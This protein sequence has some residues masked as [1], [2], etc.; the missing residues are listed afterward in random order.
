MTRRP[1]LP[2]TVYILSYIGVAPFRHSRIIGYLLLPETYRSL[3]RL[4]SASDTKAFTIHLCS[5]TI[6]FNPIS[7]SRDIANIIFYAYIVLLLI[8]TSCDFYVLFVIV[9]VSR[10]HP[11]SDRNRKRLVFLIYNFVFTCR[12]KGLTVNRVIIRI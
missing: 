3:S 11:T 4:S 6:F 9:C 12:N 8:C 2:L 10:F 5:L 7:P 1:Y